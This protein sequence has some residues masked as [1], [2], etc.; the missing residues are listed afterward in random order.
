V[1]FVI[2]TVF[3]FARREDF[4]SGGFAIREM[5]KRYRKESSQKE[6]EEH[7]DCKGK[8]HAVNHASIPAKQ[9]E[10]AGVKFRPH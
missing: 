8:I 9:E 1:K 3:F 5:A 4:L 10:L 2:L 6:H 7:K